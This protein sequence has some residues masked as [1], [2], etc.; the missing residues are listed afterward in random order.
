M[1][2]YVYIIQVKG[3]NIFKVG[4][5][6]ERPL[7]RLTE[8]QV[9]NHCTLKL[10]YALQHQQYKKIEKGLHS[11]LAP[12]HKRGEWFIVDLDTVLRYLDTVVTHIEMKQVV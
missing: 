4:E 6:N 7:N 8:L 11:V 1:M 3:E 2:G 5:T 12:Y 10:V 9:G